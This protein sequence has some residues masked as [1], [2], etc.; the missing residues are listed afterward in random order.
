MF[1]PKEVEDH[2]EEVQI[3]E[4]VGSFVALRN[5]DEVVE[6]TIAITLTSR[7]R[8]GSAIIAARTS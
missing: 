5:D 2:H 8:R 6:L 3:E 4:E 1:T 7:G